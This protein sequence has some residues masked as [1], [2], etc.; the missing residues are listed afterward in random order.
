MTPM[1]QIVDHT[2]KTGG[3]LRVERAGVRIVDAF[4]FAKA[5]DELFVREQVQRIVTQ[6]N[7]IDQGPS[8]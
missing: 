5:A 3:Y 7:T 8:P 6:M 2:S 1:W 4:P